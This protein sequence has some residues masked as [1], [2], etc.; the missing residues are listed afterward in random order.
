MVLRNEAE[1]IL[2]PPSGEGAA[3]DM[4]ETI[5]TID[6]PMISD[7]TLVAATMT[8]VEV[9]L[10]Y[11]PSPDLASPDLASSDLASSEVLTNAPI[12]A[13][14][15][16]LDS[17]SIKALSAVAAIAEAPIVA[18]PKVE[19]I[20]TSATIDDKV[21][22]T[23]ALQRIAAAIDAPTV[24][25]IEPLMADDPPLP[26]QEPRVN[27]HAE[28]VARPS[29]KPMWLAA[30]IAV[31]CI[32]ATVGAFAVSGAAPPVAQPVAPQSSLQ[33]LAVADDMQAL[34]GTIAQLRN[35][36]AALKASL[37]VGAKST[38]T[39]FA[40]ISERLD[41]IQLEQSNRSKANDGADRSDRRVDFTPT[42]DA[43]GS[44]PQSAVASMQSAQPIV[45][46]WVLRDVN[47]GVATI[48]GARLGTIEVEAGDVVPGLGRIDAI[49]K[50]N[51]RW[52]V[53]T[54]RGLVTAFR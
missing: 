40:K 12:S 17:S 54:S 24:A 44:L 20:E 39:Q 52:V 42:R 50:Q 2:T 48:Q 27:S 36:L 1:T 6:A 35:E 21:A 53:V 3:S 43:T 33:S 26:P 46:G 16:K 4:G 28:A 30:V 37:E 9:A 31:A 29:K 47:N 34:Q 32:G 23:K 7:Q 25:P 8:S 14:L 18:T 38:N 45:P 19:Q 11:V 5:P 15:P 49:R 22:T 41:R 51:N 10:P 13:N